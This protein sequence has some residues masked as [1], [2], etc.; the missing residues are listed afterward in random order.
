MT[1]Q[2][3]VTFRAQADINRAAYHIS[4]VLKNPQ[5]ADDFLD[6]VEAEIASLA[7]MPE[8]Y[9]IVH[10]EVLAFWK[11]R[12][13]RIKNYLAFYTFNSKT[14]T[15]YVVRVLYGKSNWQSILRQD[16]S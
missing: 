10:D 5:A 1:C 2:I 6:A 16:F 15:V 7:E 13:T 11:I 8:R 14:Q 4:H 3:R 9:A 12:F